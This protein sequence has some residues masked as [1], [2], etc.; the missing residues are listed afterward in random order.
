[1]RFYIFIA[2][3]KNE[4]ENETVTS[5]SSSRRDSDTKFDESTD[6]R[7]ETYQSQSL[8]EKCKQYLYFYVIRCKFNCFFVYSDLREID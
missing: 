6:I 4:Q 1:M 3:G 8:K 2:T 5:D 7:N